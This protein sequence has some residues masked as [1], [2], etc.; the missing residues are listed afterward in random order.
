M[1]FITRD[2]T[3][4]D[5]PQVLNLIKELALFEKEPE[6]V[7]VTVDDLILDGFGTMLVD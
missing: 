3:K 2:A 6:A 5:M 7:E 4:E 1:E